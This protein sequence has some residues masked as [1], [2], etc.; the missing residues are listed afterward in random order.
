MKLI[1]TIEFFK[2]LQNDIRDYMDR[3]PN[4]TDLYLHETVAEIYLSDAIEALEK[5]VPCK[6]E[7]LKGKGS[8][9]V[10]GVC[11]GIMDL[12]QRDLN[13]CPNCGQAIDWSEV[14]NEIENDD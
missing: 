1:T 10:C 5:Q 4:A 14:K 2:D 13:Y 3:H 9:T 6:L 7:K 8:I 12:E 11:Y